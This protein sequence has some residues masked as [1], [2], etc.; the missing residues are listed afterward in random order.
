MCNRSSCLKRLLW[1]TSLLGRG[2]FTD[3]KTLP[4]GVRAK[5]VS[6]L[7]PHMAPSSRRTQSLFSYSVFN[8]QTALEHSPGQGP[9]SEDWG[10]HSPPQGGAGSA[11]EDQ[12]PLCVSLRLLCT[13]SWPCLISACSDPCSTSLTCSGPLQCLPRRPRAH[14]SCQ[15]W[16][17]RLGTAIANG[18]WRVTCVPCVPA[19]ETLSQFHARSTHVCADG[20]GDLGLV[21]HR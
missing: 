21:R 18:R 13:S 15:A 9:C 4:H 5:P 8:R 3:T 7:L 6:S 17:L 14:T 2:V 11:R 20:R 12:H 10:I 1:Q 16:P 19:L